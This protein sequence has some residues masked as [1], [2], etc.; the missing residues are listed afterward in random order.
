VSN[1]TMRNGNPIDQISELNSTA[2]LINQ[3]AAMYGMDPKQVEESLLGIDPSMIPSLSD[4]T[5]TVSTQQCAGISLSNANNCSLLNNKIIN[6]TYGIFLNTSGNVTL[7]QN[8]LTHNKYG[9][10]VSASVS[11]EYINNIDTSNTIDGK[12]IYYLANEKGRTVPIDAGYAALINCT[13][14]TVENLTLTNNYNGLLIVDTNNSAIKNNMVTGNYEGLRILNSSRNVF[15]NN[16]IND[17]KFGFFSD[18]TFLNDIDPSNKMNEQPVY[19]WINQHGKSIPKNAGYV[20]LIDCSDITI[21]N[22]NISNVEVGLLLQN[23][24]SSLVEKNNLTNTDC[25][26]KLISS[27][28]NL[29]NQNNIA[30]SQDGIDIQ[31]K[32]TNNTVAENNVAGN[33]YTAIS[34]QS[35]ESSKLQNNSLIKNQVAILI[36]GSCSNTLTGNNLESNNYA[37]Q[38][39]SSQNY[40]SSSTESDCQHNTII[41]NN[42]LLNKVAISFSSN[43]ANNTLYHNNFANNTQQAQSS[44]YSS[45]QMNI[46]DNGVQGNY[47]SNYNGT[48]VNGDGIGD[49]SFYVFQQ[50]LTGGNPPRMPVASDQDCFPLMNPYS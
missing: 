22:L 25:A 28:N 43:I 11:T 7:R 29:I 18:Y 1:F 31:E 33:L 37:L 24:T 38:L 39:A 41:E 23:T 27:S 30:S 44:S 49:Q 47:W 45:A 15:R 5:N 12:P 21:Q 9:F 48:D 2:A 50:N 10:G 4:L 40:Y 42:F 8:I 17:N 14:M 13:D 36:T 26:I 6:S 46:W 32:S 20:A 35:S 34:I 16:I 19:V 3:I